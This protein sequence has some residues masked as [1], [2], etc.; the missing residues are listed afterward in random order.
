M[1]GARTAQTDGHQC[2]IM[3]QGRDNPRLFPESRLKPVSKRQEQI[4]GR[5]GEPGP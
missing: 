3:T 5:C 4:G 2:G 1:P